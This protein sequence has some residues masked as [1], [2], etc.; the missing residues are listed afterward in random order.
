MPKSD[1]RRRKNPTSREQW[2]HD[3]KRN[4]PKH[5]W[6]G[7]SIAEGGHWEIVNG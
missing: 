4:R 5:K 7:G 3:K 6:V 1:H 2:M